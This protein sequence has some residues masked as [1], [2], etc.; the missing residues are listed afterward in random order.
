MADGFAHAA[1]TAVCIQQWTHR[2]VYNAWHGCADCVLLLHRRLLRLLRQRQKLEAEPR[3]KAEAGPRIRQRRELEADLP[4]LAK[5]PVTTNPPRR[6]S[7]AEVPLT[8]R[9]AAATPGR[10]AQR[11]AAPAFAMTPALA[12][13]PRPEEVAARQAATIQTAGA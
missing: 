2:R 6:W 10:L 9:L 4:P 5:G 11:I 13:R 8:T 1:A 7:V 3:F 12:T